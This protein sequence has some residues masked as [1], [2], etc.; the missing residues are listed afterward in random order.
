MLVLSRQR[1]ESIIIGDNIVI[2]VVDIRGDKVRLGIQAPTEIPVHRQE[3]YEAIQR[4]NIR[5]TG[6]DP[7]E[8]PPAA[9]KFPNRRNSRPAS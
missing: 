4:E 1:D 2:T 7:E 9:N 6:G 8:V 5:A 3:V